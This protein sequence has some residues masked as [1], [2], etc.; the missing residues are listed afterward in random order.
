MEQGPTEKTIIEQCIRE[1][2][3]LPDAIANAPELKFGLELFYMAFMDLT[4]CR[5]IGYGAG[6]IPW[7]A[8]QTWCAAYDIQGEQREDLFYHVER[9]DKSY[10]DWSVKKQK[11]V[12]Q[13]TK[14]PK[15][16]RKP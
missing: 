2:R 8:I 10:L 5:S 1:R 12:T 9:L 4:S 15:R 13:S 16:G 3:P 11:A 6:P 14:P 7:S